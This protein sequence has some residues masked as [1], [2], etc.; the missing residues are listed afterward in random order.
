[1]TKYKARE[2]ALKYVLLSMIDHTR[3]M[4]VRSGLAA[5]ELRLGSPSGTFV[6]S[7]LLDSL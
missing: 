7:S 3:I 6:D 4:M 5:V 2:L 1:M